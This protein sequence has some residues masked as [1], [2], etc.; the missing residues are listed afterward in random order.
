[1]A[2]TLILSRNP[3]W[4]NAARAFMLRTAASIVTAS[5]FAPITRPTTSSG[6]GAAAAAHRAITFLSDRYSSGKCVWAR[7]FRTLGRV[8]Q[9]KRKMRLRHPPEPQILQPRPRRRAAQ[10]RQALLRL[11][12][13]QVLQQ[14]PVRRP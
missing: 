14:T 9:K 12:Q 4:S 8:R 11:A 1:M 13:I 7:I 2:A 10:Q 5:K 3:E 6:N